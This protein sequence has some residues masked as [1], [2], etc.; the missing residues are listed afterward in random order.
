V[1]PVRPRNPG[2]DPVHQDDPTA[3]RTCGDE[4]ERMIGPRSFASD[5]AVGEAALRVCF[6][7]FCCEVHRL[8]LRVRP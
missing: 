8:S 6:E 4:Q 3:Q 2:L 7:P 1:V 5:C